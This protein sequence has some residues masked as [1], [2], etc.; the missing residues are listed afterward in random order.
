MC[1][2]MIS[3]S[4]EFEFEIRGFYELIKNRCVDFRENPPVSV[5]EE[6]DAVYTATSK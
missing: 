5:G 2:E 4:G 1:N 3:I 6:W